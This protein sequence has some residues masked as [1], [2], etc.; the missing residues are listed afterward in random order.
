MT[1]EARCTVVVNDAGQYSVWAEGAAPPDGWREAG[2]S[3]S[4]AECL[5]H[6][7]EVWTDLLPGAR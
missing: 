7:D 5:A 1:G 4:R 2:F 6:V 3:G